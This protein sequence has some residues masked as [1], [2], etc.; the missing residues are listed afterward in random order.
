M[1]ER[2]RRAGAAPE[3]LTELDPA[4]LESFY[5]VPGGIRFLLPSRSEVILSFREL[6]DLLAPE[7][8]LGRLAS[9]P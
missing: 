4:V 8:P 2:L 7:G 9:S 6:S 3:G 1:L 5:L